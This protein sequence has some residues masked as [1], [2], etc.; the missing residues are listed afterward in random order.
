MADSLVL[1]C[2]VTMCWCFESES[3]PY[4]DAVFKAVQAGNAMTPSIWP[5]EVANVL[6]VSERRNRL[7]EVAAT[8]FLGILKHLAIRV[9]PPPADDTLHVLLALAREHHLSVYDASYLELAL[10]Y[11]CPLA[12]LDNKLS[13]AAKE[14][15]VPLFR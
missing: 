10:R 14:R 3:N 13:R 11:G 9:E 1:D 4:A 2:S 7:S 8:Q 5:F 15:R 6:L 12:T